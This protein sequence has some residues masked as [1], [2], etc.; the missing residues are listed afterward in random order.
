MISWFLA[1]AFKFNLCTAYAPADAILC[2][3]GMVLEVGLYRLTAVVTLELE[4][5]WFQPLN[6]KC[7]FLVSKPEM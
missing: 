7:D 5:V 3:N 6:L 2:P 1:F 4:S